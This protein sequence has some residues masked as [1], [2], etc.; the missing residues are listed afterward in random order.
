LEA[1]VSQVG[2]KTGH[3]EHLKGAPLLVTHGEVHDRALAEVGLDRQRLYVTN[4]VTHFKFVERGKRR[5]HQTPRLAEIAACRPW[6]EAE[7]ALIKPETLVAL[8]ATAARALFGS[9]FRLMKERGRVFASSWAPRSIGTLHPSAVLRGEDE[10]TQ[11]RLYRMLVEDLRL[12]A[13]APSPGVATAS[14]SPTEER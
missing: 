5:I 8:G 2:E 14:R 1:R 11:A 13:V 7:L 3:Q 12:A 10:A 6:L 4:A 9:E